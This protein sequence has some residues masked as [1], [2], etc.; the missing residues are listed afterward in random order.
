MN[1][2]ENIVGSFTYLIVREKKGIKK[3]LFLKGK[4]TEAFI[5]LTYR[6]KCL[7]HACLLDSIDSMIIIIKIK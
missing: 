4:K 5:I 1:V 6:E 3:N 2:I 7:C